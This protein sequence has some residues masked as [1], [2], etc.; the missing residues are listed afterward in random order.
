MEKEYKE[1]SKLAKKGINKYT[2]LSL[3]NM[4]K[5]AKLFINYTGK[6]PNNVDLK[7]EFYEFVAKNNIRGKR[8]ELRD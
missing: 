4:K 1:F 3:I 6:N 5:Y 7:E 2:R 8:I